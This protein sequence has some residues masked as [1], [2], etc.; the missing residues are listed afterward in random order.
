MFQRVMV[1]LDGSDVAEQ[2]LEILPSVAGDDAVVYLVGVTEL[3]GPVVSNYFATTAMVGTDV[4]YP[5]GVPIQS[6]EYDA[7]IHGVR[8]EAKTYLE[9][10]TQRL[11]GLYQVKSLVLEGE[12]V[13]RL[14]AASDEVH[15]DVIVMCSRRLT[16]LSRFFMGSV[17]HEIIDKA[18]IPVVVV[19]NK[20]EEDD[21]ED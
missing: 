3:P 1:P 5:V 11:S 10:I 17:T 12:P 19:P 16:G 9:G 21:D 7:V 13:D 4:M 8:S 2:A 6:G 14:L 18:T 15:A 20:L